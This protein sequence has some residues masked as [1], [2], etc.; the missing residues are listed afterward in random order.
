MAVAALDCPP[1]TNVH[2]RPPAH[3]HP[4][5]RSLEDDRQSAPNAGSANRLLGIA[6]GLGGSFGLRTGLDRVCPRDDRDARPPARARRHRATKT[7]H[8]Q[9]QSPARG[10]RRSQARAVAD[11]APDDIAGAS[12][13]VDGR[14]GRTHAVSCILVASKSARMDHRRSIE[15][16]PPPRHRWVLPADGRGPGSC[17]CSGDCRRL[18]AAER[19]AIRGAVRHPMAGISC[20]RTLGE[21]AAADG[22]P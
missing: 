3:R 11:R 6:G 9:T 1:R 5:G 17:R 15:D 19:L 4:A 12:G 16:Q 18:G 2:G 22:N 7:R 13:V 14:C 20:C 8:L 10:R 21:P